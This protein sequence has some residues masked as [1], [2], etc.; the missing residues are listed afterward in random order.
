MFVRDFLHSVANKCLWW[1]P[2]PD[3][4]Y[5]DS[6]PPCDPAARVWL[7]RITG[8]HW[9]ISLQ[10]CL[11]RKKGNSV[12]CNKL[13]L[14]HRWSRNE[15]KPIAENILQCDPSIQPGK[16][17]R[18]ILVHEWCCLNERVRRIVLQRYSCCTMEFC[19]VLVSESHGLTPR[20]GRGGVSLI[21]VLYEIWEQRVIQSS[22]FNKPL[23]LPTL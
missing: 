6:V 12:Q 21:F 23:H 15:D 19:S 5:T 3:L 8:I 20:G 17:W 10:S 9:D 22:S 14:V 11:K 16:R 1:N 4:G 13:W 7:S 2:F 18:G